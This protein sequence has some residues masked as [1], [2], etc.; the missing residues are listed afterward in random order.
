[1]RKRDFIWIFAAALA[2]S[3]PAIS[4]AE[5]EG[6]SNVF[7]LGT[8]E[9]VDKA[10][11]NRNVTVE[12]V[13]SEEMRKFNRKDVANAVNLLPG[14]TLSTVGARNEATVFIRGFDIKHAPLFLDGIPIYV[15]YDGY[16]DLGRFGTYD[17]SQIVVSKGFTSVLY[18]PNTMG[19]AINLVSRKPQEKF[20]GDV[21]A[22]IATGETYNAFFNVGTNQGP[23]Y[24]QAGASYLDSDHTVLS[25]NF[26]PNPLNAA[27]EDGGDRINSYRTDKKYSLK[28]GLTPGDDE[29]A[30][31]YSHYTSERGAPP[32]VGNLQGPTYFQWKSWDKD[33][34]YFSSK[35]SIGESSYVK[36]RLYYDE[37]SNSLFKYNDVTYSTTNPPSGFKSWYDDYAL[38]GSV[39]AGTRAIPRHDIRASAHYRVDHHEEHNEGEPIQTNEDRLYSIGVEDTIDI[40]K[41]L[42]AIAGAS[43]DKLKTEKAEDY[44]SDIS[45]GPIGMFE[46]PT[47]SADAFNP[48]LGV[49]YKLSDTDTAYAS[50]AR[51]TR[52]PSIKDKYSFRLGNAIPNPDLKPEVSVN[53]EVGYNGVI[54]GRYGLRAA[55]F[56]NDISDFVLSKVVNPGPPTVISQNQNIS[57]VKQYGA[58]L[59]VNGQIFDNLEA[60]ANYTYIHRSNQTNTDKLTGVPKHKF[61]T[62][63]KYSPIDKVSL[64]GDLEYNTQRFSNS[65]GT[66]IAGPFTVA[67]AKV[68]Y[69]PVK[70]LELEAGAR[71]V[72][73]ANYEL[74]EG[75]PEPGRTFFGNVYY[76]F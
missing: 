14:V 41:N 27:K 61:F 36:V 35:T 19:G 50:I 65:T 46:S 24:L 58:E 2:V 33:S 30:L 5:D 49:F 7:T 42:Y 74:E 38:G 76:K 13:D 37:Y 34:L 59:E 73:D 39:E 31:S 23:W 10:D 69:E 48:Q 3:T 54:S 21:G 56:Y 43:Y 68:V 18:G 72:L 51:K 22:G 70:N 75:F 40:T 8:I 1:M 52:L 47:G 12:K 62:Y 44:N 29:Y 64:I 32:Y 20:E 53:Y 57:S 45:K 66:R 63:A 55:L 6:S 15:P 67:N 4:H 16:P 28:V 71:N 11:K 25:D 60:G 9:L 17:L 26:T